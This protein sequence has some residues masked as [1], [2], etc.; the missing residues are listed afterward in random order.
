[1]DTLSSTKEA[2]IYNGKRTTSFTSGWQVFPAPLVKEVVLFPLY[3]LAS[4][5]E[6]KVSIGTWI[7][8]WAFYFVLLTSISVFVPVPYWL[9]DCGFVSRAWSQVGWFP[10]FHSSFSR[11][12]WLF[13]AFCISIQI[14]KLFVLVLWRIL[15]VAWE[16]LHW[17]YRLLWIVYSFSQYWFFQSMNRVYFSIYLCPLWF[18]SS[19]F[20]S[21]LYID[22]LFL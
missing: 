18:L 7:Y 4:F 1:M 10:Q 22:L 3:I 5:V 11:L 9:D 14:V 2:R 13:E 8:L 21:F 6:D 12:L 17:I 15:L 16:G 19:V 20:Y